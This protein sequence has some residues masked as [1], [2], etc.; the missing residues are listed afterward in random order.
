MSQ[1]EKLFCGKSGLL[2]NMR[3]GGSLDGAVGGY[4]QLESFPL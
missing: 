2:Q 4:G 3:K 1:F